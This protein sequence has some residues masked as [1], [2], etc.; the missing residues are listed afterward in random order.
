[1]RA[2]YNG[3]M[4]HLADI[5]ALTATLRRHLPVLKAR[6]H[7]R[8]LAVFGSYVRHEQRPDSDLDLLVTFDDPPSL[9]KFLELEQYLTDA[10]GVD[11]DLVMQDVLRPT[12][13]KQILAEQ[14]PV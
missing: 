8:T 5:E 14:V 13:G 3:G 6:Y 4:E 10:L 12:I 11:V 7:V 9:L 2:L 1:M